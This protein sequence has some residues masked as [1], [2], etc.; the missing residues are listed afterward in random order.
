MFKNYHSY[1]NLYIVMHFPLAF[2]SKIV[3]KAEMDSNNL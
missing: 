1:K 3:P 2:F